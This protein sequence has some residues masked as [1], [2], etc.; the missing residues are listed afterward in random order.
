MKQQ[1]KF[2]YEQAIP[3]NEP[4]RRCRVA[5]VYSSCILPGNKPILTGILKSPGKPF[6]L[7]KCL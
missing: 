6:S 7:V 5:D 1:W 3:G 2:T 4:F